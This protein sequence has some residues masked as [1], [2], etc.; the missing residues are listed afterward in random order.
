MATFLFLLL[1]ALKELNS[2]YDSYVICVLLALD[3]NTILR[4]W[5]WH[6]SGR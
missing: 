5:L 1:H 2:A 3:S 6:R 4:W